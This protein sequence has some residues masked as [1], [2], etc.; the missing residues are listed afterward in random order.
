MRRKKKKVMLIQIKRGRKWFLVT[1]G[2]EGSPECVISVRGVTKKELSLVPNVKIKDFVFLASID[3]KN[4]RGPLGFS[5]FEIL[6]FRSK[7]ETFDDVGML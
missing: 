4:I 1:A 6:V 2:K 3:G 5:V 7:I